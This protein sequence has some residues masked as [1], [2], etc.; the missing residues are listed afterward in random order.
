MHNLALYFP[1]RF[2]M[3]FIYFVKNVC[4]ICSKMYV[5]FVENCISKMYLSFV[6]KCT[7][8]L[9]QIVCILRSKMYVHFVTNYMY[10][11]NKICASFFAK[12]TCPFQCHA[13]RHLKLSFRP[14][15]MTSCSEHVR[16]LSITLPG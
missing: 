7:Y 14:F 9:W 8:P 3:I 1:K 2:V 13:F 10:R 6:A 11:R 5:S 15:V 12:C 4:I 16:V